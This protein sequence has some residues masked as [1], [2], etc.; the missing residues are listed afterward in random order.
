MSR[1]GIDEKLLKDSIS[2]GH[3]EMGA[4]LNVPR[5]THRDYVNALNAALEAAI[6][7]YIS[8]GVYSR[9]MRHPWWDVVDPKEPSL[10]PGTPEM[11]EAVRSAREFIDGRY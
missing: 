5:P 10:V 2:Y 8:G 9:D 7:N 6:L 11:E 4:T 3:S 1:D